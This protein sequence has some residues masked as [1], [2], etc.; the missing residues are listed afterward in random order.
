MPT[1]EMY[2]RVLSVG[3]C[4]GSLPAGKRG[5]GLHYHLRSLQVGRVIGLPPQDDPE[6]VPGPEDDSSDE[7][8]FVMGPY[9]V[10]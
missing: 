10:N 8:G 7:V 4:V 5:V 3:G 6:L 9:A 2:L 1:P